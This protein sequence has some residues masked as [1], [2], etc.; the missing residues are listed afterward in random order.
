[1]KVTVS[2]GGKFHGFYLAKCLQDHGFLEQL[3]TSYPKFE[4]KKSG[5]N[6]AKVSSI[7]LKEVVSRFWHKV[8]K[9]YP[10]E[11]ITAVLF[12]FI[13]S[14]IINKK[15]DIYI[16]WSSYALKT[17]K[18][19]KKKN[20]KAIII[21]E[22]GSSHIQSQNELL[23]AAGLYKPI[24]KRIIKR[25]VAEYELVDFISLPSLFAKR[26]FIE[27]NIDESKLFVNNYGVDLSDF[28]P[29]QLEKNDTF[30]VGYVGS[31]SA[32]KNIKGLIEACKV[33]IEK[34]LNISLHLIG[35]LDTETFDRKILVAYPWIFYFGSQKQSKLPIFYNRM[36]IFVLN[37]IQDGFGMVILQ[38]LSCGV[39]V[40]ATE[41]TGGPDI[42]KNGYNGF[43]IP[44]NDEKSLCEQIEYCYNHREQTKKMGENARKSV[45]SGLSWDD[46][47]RRYVTF[48]ESII[49]K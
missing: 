3:V 41:N 47:G 24:S 9:K 43:I 29:D 27:K 17:I 40:I 11:I 10:Y 45:E 33:L 23:E 7:V 12:D 37:S 8:F 26:T 5:I 19:L 2:V 42:I 18:R 38:A 31:L 22:R 20:P 36:D 32:Q 34:G 15:S 49:K 16:I 14:L 6:V 48:L 4:V 39:P 28:K 21:L 35:G 30:V 13:A 1:M 25:E 44:I 46:Y